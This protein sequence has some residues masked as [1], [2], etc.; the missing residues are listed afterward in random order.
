MNADAAS[1]PGRPAGRLV[2]DRL[3]PRLPAELWRLVEEAQGGDALAP[4]TVIVPTRYCGLQLREIWG[5]RGFANVRFSMMADLAEALGA[6]AAS[7]GGRRRPLTAAIEG[8]WIRRVMAG[9]GGA[10]RRVGGHPATLASLRASFRDLR[11]ADPAVIEAHRRSGGVGSEVAGLFRRL[12][13]DTAGAWY[14]AEDLARA[15]AET[16]AADGPAPWGDLG[17][18][19]LYL[20][21]GLSPAQ[22]AL[23]AALARAGRCSAVVGLTGDERADA[24]ANELA[25]ALGRHL[26]PASPA[27]CGS[28]EEAGGAGGTRLHI[29]PSAHEE[30]RWVIRRIAERAGAGTPLRRMAILY[31]AADPY[32]ALVPDELR[33]AGIPAAGPDRTTLADTP[34]GRLLIGAL[35]LASGDLG[36]AEVMDW[37]TGCPVGPPP[38]IDP[39]EF[40]PSRWES[41]T[42]AAGII[43]GLEQ[44]QQRLGGHADTLRREAERGEL[45]GSIPEARA[46][47]MRARARSAQVAGDFVTG[48][49]DDLRPPDPHASGPAATWS[50]HCRWAAGLFDRYMASDAPADRAGAAGDVADRVGRALTDLAAVDDVTGSTDL[51]EFRR[52]VEEALRVPVGGLGPSGRGVFVSSLSAARGMEFEAVWMV[53][54]IEGRAPPA[55]RPDPLLPEPAVPVPGARSR[56]ERAA[57]DERFDYLSALACAQDMTLSHPAADASSDSRAY[58]S[59]WFLERA[60]ALAGRTVHTSDLRSLADAGWMSVDRSAA[61]AL[62]RA[63][64][65]TFADAH[66]H[67][68]G[69]LLEWRA[70][71][72][73]TADHPLARRGPLQRALR[74]ARARAGPGLTE[75]DGNLSAAAPDARFAGAL[76]ARPV[77]PTSLESWAACPFRYFLGYVLRLGA[78]EAPEEIT[79]ITPLERGSLVHEIL[80]H[81]IAEA[82]REG[83]MPGPEEPWGEGGRERIVEIAEER[84]GDAEERGVTGLS[85]MWRIE[86]LNIVSDLHTFLEEDS[87][88]RRR[89]GTTRVM[90]E[91][92][93]GFDGADQAGLDLGDGTRVAFRGSADRV[94]IGAGGAALVIDYKTGSRS[95]YSG[96]DRDVIDRGRRLQLGVYSLAARSLAPEAERIGAAYWFVTSRGGFRFAPSRAASME[97]ERS[98]RRLREGIGAIVGGIRS[99]AFA[100]NP[101][102]PGWGGRGENCRFCDFD[103][104]CPSR[105]AE[106]WERKSPDPLLAGYLGLSQ[107]AEDVG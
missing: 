45:D 50:E 68:L 85:L 23:A 63:G 72:R 51:E 46:E 3:S 40:N 17:P 77:S 54:M 19:V 82:V 55:V 75:F 92:R 5:E 53:G 65:G 4:V 21:R 88:L 34:P 32:A 104:L 95:P 18:I 31:R 81:F 8:A 69:R 73:R 90:V 24:D 79:T 87:A 74:M 62:Q 58:P 70:E 80:E 38:D 93:F 7:D 78:V 60:S 47:A 10:L 39:E 28:G 26:G 48:L 66:D 42:R 64:A 94:D 36:R 97:D 35:R 49:A 2:V 99:G 107:G 44:W 89:H 84:F 103:S 96:L 37:L 1:A 43:G 13:R 106:A 56:A 91:H 15:A 57:D 20:P 86:R 41:V 30:I 6:S 33:L 25:A 83:W 29:A 9:A 16:V 27:P 76:G 52:A 22:A 102:P 59:R 98:A 67:D 14:D 71:G 105:R 12:R 100:A 61:E 101:G 11:L